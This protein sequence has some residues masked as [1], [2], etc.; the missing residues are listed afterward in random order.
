MKTSFRARLF[1]SCLPGESLRVCVHPGPSCCTSK[2]EDGYMAAV[3]SET[4]Q[5]MR[6]YSFEL[7]YLIAGH[8]KAYQGEGKKVTAGKFFQRSQVSH[9]PSWQMPEKSKKDSFLCQWTVTWSKR[10]FK[11][12]GKKLYILYIKIYPWSPVKLHTNLNKTT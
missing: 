5:K 7:K 4:Q 1:S 2:M 12:T 6:S 11:G 9:P 10:D 8:T 3:R